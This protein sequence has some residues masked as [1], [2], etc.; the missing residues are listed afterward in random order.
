MS[1][2]YYSDL[3]ELGFEDSGWGLSDI[4]LSLSYITE[5]NFGK[6]AP[7][8]KF[9]QSV[10]Y[11]YENDGTSVA[12]GE[13]GKR[14]TKTASHLATRFGLSSGRSTGFKAFARAV[15]E[16]IHLLKTFD[17]NAFGTAEYKNWLDNKGLS[18]QV[19]TVLSYMCNAKLQ[20]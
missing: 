19:V 1:S 13:K 12:G 15:Y 6:D 8:T 3:S 16:S 5:G 4:G 7:E 20:E 14:Q 18:D 2:Q 11:L 17:D 10:W 9:L